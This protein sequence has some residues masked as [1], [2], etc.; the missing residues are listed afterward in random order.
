VIQSHD[1]GGLENR[2]YQ[3]AR[4]SS[5]K[6]LNR[7]DLLGREGCPRSKP[8][9]LWRQNVIEGGLPILLPTRWAA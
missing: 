8:A 9:R 7:P 1:L 5:R 4:I 2:H 3:P 6:K